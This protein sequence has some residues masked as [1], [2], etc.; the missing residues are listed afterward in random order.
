[1][2][3]VSGRIVAGIVAG[4]RRRG[5]GLERLVDG[6]SLTVRRLEGRP[7]ALE[8]PE[9]VELSRRLAELV[10][11]PEELRA[12]AAEHGSSDS[13]RVFRR[14]GYALA[15]PRDLYKLGVRW[16][17]PSLIKPIEAEVEESDEGLVIERLRITPG[18]ADCPEIFHFI[19]G[20]LISAPKAWGHAP[21]EVR[22]ELGPRAA[23]YWIRPAAPRRRLLGRLLGALRAGLA[24]PDMLRELETQQ[25]QID[26]SYRQLEKAHARI[27]TQARELEKVNAI[28][29]ELSAHIELDRVVDTLLD[30][31]ISDLGV[32]GAELTVAPANPGEP[33]P[34]EA[35]P[36]AQPIV[37]RTGRCDGPSTRTLPLRSAANRFGS[38]V[39]WREDGTAF[40][41]DDALLERLLPWIAVA[42]DNARSYRHLEQ[43]AE[44]LQQRVRERTARLLAANHHLVREIDERKR[45]T[46]AL[47]ASETQRRASERLAS[48]GTLAA[49][50]AHEINNPIGSILAAAQMAQLGMREDQAGS[51]IAAALD[52]IVREAKRCG[53]IVRSVLQFSRDERTEK[54]TC[55]LDEIVQRAVRLT[56]PFAQENESE[57][58]TSLCDGPVWVEVNPIQI[59]QAL[60]NL[61][62]NAVEAGSQRVRIRLEEQ[63]EEARALVE[64]V[65]DGP[66]LTEEEP[67]RI[68]EPFYT[69]KRT[70]GGTGLGLSVVHGIAS[71]HRGVLKVEP[72][73]EG[74]VSALLELPTTPPPSSHPRLEKPRQAASEPDREER[75]P[76]D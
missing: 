27:Q 74:G 19:H 2:A 43:H 3:G 42:L 52:D 49:G 18:H 54:W 71:E 24:F 58:E 51:E 72:S 5:I 61:I 50:I 59:E 46:D 33:T 34:D 47:V 37:R 17:G 12:I 69:T 10:G 48:I 9:F 14:I 44:L 23:T 68:F 16:I 75:D 35:V 32:T 63:R 7:G 67:L 6:T 38:L 25:S 15:D 40:T 73:A 29:R 30:V 26:A 11:G 22:M 20:A 4:A 21:S 28:G 13:F 45:A 8:W 55:P 62:R 39:I 36:D 64:I 65:D 60:V 53:S 76:S 57:L 31:L 56:Q 41:R 66:G 70:V 1:M